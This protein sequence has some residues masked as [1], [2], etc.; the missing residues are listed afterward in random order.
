MVWE[1]TSGLANVVPMTTFPVLLPGRRAVQG[2]W[3]ND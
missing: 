1:E 3:G 2:R